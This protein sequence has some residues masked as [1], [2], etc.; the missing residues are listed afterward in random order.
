M[1]GDLMELRFEAPRGQERGL[2][3]SLLKQSYAVLLEAEPAVWGPE[4]LKW[5]RFDADVFS[6]PETIGAAVFL[7][8]VGDTIIGFASYDPREKPELGFIGHNCV[9][10]EFRNRGV[11]RQPWPTDP[12]RAVIEYLKTAGRPH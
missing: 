3:A 6:H 8:K 1:I 5:E 7:T 9:R 11:G 4:A 12:L 10:P 2:I